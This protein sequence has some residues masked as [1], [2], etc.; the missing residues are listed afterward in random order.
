MLFRVCAL[1][2]ALVASIPAPLANYRSWTRLTSEPRRISYDL[3]AQ[4]MSVAVAERGP[5]ADRWV[6]TY[7]NSVALAALK[8]DGTFPPGAVIAKEKLTRADAVHPEG[9]AFM[10]KHGKGELAKSGDWEF[11]YY[12]S[13]GAASRYDRCVACHRAG[14]AHDYVFSSYKR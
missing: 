7:A 5:H 4:C 9:V 10:L 13:A 3:S 6:M 12:P 11:L 8:S 1:A 2:V 14:A